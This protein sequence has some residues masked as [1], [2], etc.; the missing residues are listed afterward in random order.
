MTFC[1]DIDQFDTVH[2]EEDLETVA[3]EYFDL[4]DDVVI[5]DVSTLSGDLSVTAI[6][7]DDRS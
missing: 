3:R 2:V 4:D 1:V 6:P 5:D 7:G